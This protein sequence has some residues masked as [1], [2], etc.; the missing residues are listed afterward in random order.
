LGIT[1]DA[2]TAVGGFDESFGGAGYEEVDLAYRLLRAGKRVG[3]ARQAR[4]LYR[5]RTTLRGLVRQQRSYA[6]GHAF[7]LGK[8]G[9]PIDRV[10]G[11]EELRW[12]VRG[13]AST[14]IRKKEWR[15]RAVAASVLDR[16]IWLDVNRRATRR[17]AADSAATLPVDDFV[18]PLSTPVI[19]G[20]A[21]RA[22]PAQA[23][24]YA[25][26]GIE[27]RSLALAAALLRDGDC[28]VDCG[29]NVGVFTVSAAL[30][31]GERGRVVAFEPDARAR[32]LLVDNIAR[33]GV[34]GQVTVR[35]EAV[36]AAPGRLPFVQ[37]DN[38][39]VS[40][41]F[42]SSPAFSPGGVSGTEDVEIVTLDD[43]V[44]GPVDFVKIDIEGFEV[45]AL[46]GARRLLERSPDAIL[47]VELNPAAL[48][49]S[50]QTLSSLLERFPPAGWVLWLIDEQAPRAGAVRRFD[51]G[52]RAEVER[53]DAA[54]Y[55]NLLAV[56]SHRS[57]EVA[58]VV[59][60]LGSR[61]PQVSEGR[62]SGTTSRMRPHSVP[63]PA[64]E[65]RG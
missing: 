49:A 44:T 4:F 45:A 25:T 19:G 24:W 42:E 1:R 33:H 11:T 60:R 50:G 38:D 17:L 52:V 34:D 31:V 32:R 5:P 6:N 14:V 35:K 27:Q 53:A 20:L 61:D 57:E 65:E 56:P 64:A 39:L 41:F 16:W 9:R 13:A 48:D 18:V 58:A 26:E 22:R 47:I 8:E 12:L 62:T 55:G 7:F 21:F 23:R 40:G 54:W 43:A 36:G 30:Q 10:T 15:P 37:H 2:F 59:T 63:A 28:F 29:A 3:L 51:A 46:D